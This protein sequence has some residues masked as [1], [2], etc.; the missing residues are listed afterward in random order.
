MRPVYLDAELCVHKRSKLSLPE[1]KDMKMF[2]NRLFACTN[3][4]KVAQS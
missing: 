4:K 2:N 3:R 1:N